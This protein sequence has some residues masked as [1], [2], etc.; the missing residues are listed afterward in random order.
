MGFKL[1]IVWVFE[2]LTTL[3]Q[4]YVIPEYV[5]QP[6]YVLPAGAAACAQVNKAMCDVRRVAVANDT[7]SNIHCMISGQ[8]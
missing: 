6:T 2:Y 7:I 4:P 5:Q 1:I 8:H 3:A